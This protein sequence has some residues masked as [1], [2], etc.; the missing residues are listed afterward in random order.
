MSAIFPPLKSIAQ[1]AVPSTR[2]IFSVI[3]P[4]TAV[5]LSRRQ[6]AQLLLMS[7]RRFEEVLG[8]CALLSHAAARHGNGDRDG[9]WRISV[10]SDSILRQ[11]GLVW[12]LFVLGRQA[13]R[14]LWF[15]C[16]LVSLL[17]KVEWNG[18]HVSRQG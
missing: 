18:S 4:I 17:L 1:S 12:M 16:S 14:M 11:A 6:A 7:M 15:R 10:L 8:C 5:P 13:G 3:L 2:K 9:M